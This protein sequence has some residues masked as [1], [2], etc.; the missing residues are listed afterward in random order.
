[1]EQRGKSLHPPAVSRL[2]QPSFQSMS[3]SIH[4]CCLLVQGCK[5][6]E[7]LGCIDCH[8]AEFQLGFSLCEP[9]LWLGGPEGWQLERHHVFFSCHEITSLTSGSPM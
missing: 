1:M 4:R 2:Y 7:V 3:V 5:D 9:N 8:L 6:V